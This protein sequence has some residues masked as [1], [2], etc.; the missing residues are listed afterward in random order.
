MNQTPKSPPAH[1]SDMEL[2]QYPQDREHVHT[3]TDPDGRHV[4]H[5]P[6][7][8]HYLTWHDLEALTEWCRAQWG[9]TD[10]WVNPNYK[11]RR[12]MNRFYFNSGG[13]RDLFLLHLSSLRQPA[14][15]E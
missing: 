2:M 1:P 4:V 9:D 5:L 13:R 7:H 12:R 15:S 8:V 10:H 6:T 14:E 11:W 3:S